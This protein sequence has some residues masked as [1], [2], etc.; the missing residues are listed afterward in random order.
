MN[1]AGTDQPL[2]SLRHQLEAAGWCDG[3]K[4]T[5][6]S[7]GAPTLPRLIRDATGGDVDHIL[8]WWHISA[9]IR[10][11]EMTFQTL[12]SH[13][14][15]N[16]EL[17]KVH[18]LVERLRWR[19]WHGQIDNALKAVKSIF[20]FA[21]NIRSATTGRVSEAACTAAGRALDLRTYLTHN[22]GAIANYGRRQNQGKAVSTSRA[23]GLVNDIANA[24]M[25]KKQRMR[26]SPKGAHRVA[27]VRAAA[28]DGR[29]I[30]ENRRAA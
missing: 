11:V 16:T 22:S 13:L 23:E 20:D 18:E 6:L 5:V 24:R 2:S 4:L 7:D 19:I 1:L 10:H 17:A 3:T 30:D 28:L 15:E 8:D 12:A 25:G 29:L 9:R 21:W 14:N 27:T 26:W